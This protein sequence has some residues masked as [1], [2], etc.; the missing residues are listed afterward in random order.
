MDKNNVIYYVNVLNAT[1]SITKLAIS[2]IL[3]PNE[4]NEYDYLEKCN[5]FLLENASNHNVAGIIPENCLNKLDKHIWKVGSAF[6][7]INYSGYFTDYV[8]V[9]AIIAYYMKDIIEKAVELYDSK[10]ITE[11]PV[12]FKFEEDNLDELTQKL[13]P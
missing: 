9:N 11:E 5:Y 7:D 1:F 8:K 4:H 10:T 13:K 3:R 12:T 6:T 2:K